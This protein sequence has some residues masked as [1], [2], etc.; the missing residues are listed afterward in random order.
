MHV[1][2]K[3]KMVREEI[4][5]DAPQERVWRLFSDIEGWPRWNPICQ[6]AAMVKGRPW[7]VGSRFRFTIKPWW[8][9][10][11]ITPTVVE[12]DAPRQVTW[13]GR[14]PGFYGQH[15]FA[16]EPEEAGTRVISRE[17]FGG[18]LHWTTALV[19]PLGK[20]RELVIEWLDAI[21]AEAE[22]REGAAE[23]A[24]SDQPT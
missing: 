3:V 6:E 7:E 10:M 13:L 1:I 20:V 23:T 9:A 5:V 8:L 19:S 17:L 16:F 4:F 21:K 22:R 11:N 15:T 14:W 12:S 2:A 24:E 18:P